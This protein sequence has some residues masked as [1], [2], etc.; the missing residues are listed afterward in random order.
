[1]FRK[2]LATIIKPYGDKHINKLPLDF[3]YYPM[4][5]QPEQSTLAQ[6]N[7]F[8]NQIS[9][10]EN[11]SKSLPLGF[12]LIVKEHPWGRGNRP[13]WQYKYISNFHNVQFCDANSIEIIKKSKAVLSISGTTLIEA[14]V[15]DKPAIMFGKNYFE[16]SELIHKVS[17]IS[18]LPKTFPQ[19]L[20]H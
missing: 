6:G 16:F 17:D 13:N 2:S 15:L 8:L 1:M 14:L 7:W 19:T 18:D 12:T 9:L 10:I 3:I 20:L 5:F 11:I 4:H